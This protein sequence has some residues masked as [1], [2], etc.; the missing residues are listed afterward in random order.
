VKHFIIAEIGVNHD[1]KYEKAIKLIDHAISSGA[2]AV[3]FQSFAASR[4]STH[5]APKVDYQ[6]ARDFHSSH[7]E[8]L[9]NLELSFEEQSR[10]KDYCD[11]SKIEFISTPYGL[12]D[13]RF[14]ISIGVTKFKVASADIVDTPLHELIAS[15]GKLTIASTGMATRSEI[16]RIC[17][18]YSSFETPLVL[19]HTTSEY[20][21][22]LENA[23]LV[24]IEYLKSLNP[25]AVGYSD[26]TPT[27]LC[28]SMAVAMGC[29]YFEKHL[30]SDK[31]D[32]GP[33]HAASLDPSEFKDFVR[34]I[35]EAEKALGSASAGRSI[36]EEQMASVSRKS[37]HYKV[38]IPQGGFLKEE[39]LMLLRPGDGILWDSRSLFVGRR[40]VRNV[41]PGEQLR[42]EDLV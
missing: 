3:K 16:E 14:L 4:L 8:M 1:G 21:A 6:N 12:E 31:T 26:H 17:A 34:S 15:F 22:S 32:N 20:P 25:F 23:N 13:A 18:I 41:F 7:F 2:D 30:T 40:L 10:I 9:K 42:P 28:A 24:K 27:S 5:R 38:A 11:R 35:R 39:D 19:M 29:T 36:K 37:L 33:D